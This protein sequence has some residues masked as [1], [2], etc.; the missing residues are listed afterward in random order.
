[1]N[2][3]AAGTE[4]PRHS[5]AYFGCPVSEFVGLGE[6]EVLGRLG[7]AHTFSLE[8]AQRGAWEAEVRNLQGVLRPADDGYVFFELSIP[9]MGKRAD[10][11]LSPT[12]LEATDDAASGQAAATIPELHLK[13][14]IRSF[15]DE[16]VSE[17][18]GALV[19]GDAAQA[20]EISESLDRYPI[21]LTRDLDSA[22][23]W[24]RRRARGSE[25]FGLVASSNA[26]RL[27]AEGLQVPRW[28]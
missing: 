1:M 27:K 16:R 17:F 14:N 22:R 15:R 26:I 8:L 18:I 6:D 25:R 21:E 2:D 5:R 13:V 7:G 24:L 23:E 4:G 9:R 10:V 3:A 28:A 19:A 20:A 12:L 11:V